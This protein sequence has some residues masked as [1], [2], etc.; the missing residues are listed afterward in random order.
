MSKVLNFIFF[1]VFEI[2]ASNL[3]FKSE[4]NKKEKKQKNQKEK[5]K[6]GN[7]IKETKSEVVINYVKSLIFVTIIWIFCNSARVILNLE[8]L[9]QYRIINDNKVIVYSNNDYYI[10]LD[11]DIMNNELIIYKG[12]QEKINN[13]NVYSISKKF[14]KVTIK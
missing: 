6:N 13:T 5:I 8:L 7:V 12:H 10:T 11:C 4:N 1:V 2:V 3:V 9:K 14:D